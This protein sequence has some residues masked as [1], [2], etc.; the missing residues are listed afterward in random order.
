MSPSG[1]LLGVVAIADQASILGFPG[2]PEVPNAIGPSWRPI[3][4]ER[5]G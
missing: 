5:D 1:R 4:R 3:P 2:S